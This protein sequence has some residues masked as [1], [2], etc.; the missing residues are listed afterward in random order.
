M[1]GRVCFLSTLLILLMCSGLFAQSTY[2]LSYDVLQTSNT[3]RTIDKDELG[4]VYIMD[5]TFCSAQS[6]TECISLTKFDKN[7]EMQWNQ[8]YNLHPP[9]Q[10]RGGGQ[11]C[12]HVSDGEIVMVGDEELRPDYHRYFIAYWDT[13]GSLLDTFF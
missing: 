13:A 8:V 4:N 10:Y 6:N 11:G 1:K 5:Y 12:L 3:S 7:G 2:S 9:Y